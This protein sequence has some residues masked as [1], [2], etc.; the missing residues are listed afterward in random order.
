MSGNPDNIILD[1][2]QT[3]IG[4]AKCEKGMEE[5]NL[6]SIEAAV[7]FFKGVRFYITDK[8]VVLE[9]F[10]NEHFWDKFKSFTFAQWGLDAQGFY[11][12]L[13]MNNRRKLIDWYNKKMSILT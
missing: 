7:E 10:Q 3:K 1:L 8:S 12:S 13:D 11:M 6:D 4:Q 9:I 2:I 5:V